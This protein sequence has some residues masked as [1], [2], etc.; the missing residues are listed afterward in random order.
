MYRSSCIKAILPS[1]HQSCAQLCCY[2]QA[3]GCRISPY[4]Q[5]QIT[6]SLVGS[7]SVMLC[8]M[9]FDA[10]LLRL[11]VLPFLLANK[12]TV[13]IMRPVPSISIRPK[14]APKKTM[15]KTIA[16]S[17]STEPRIPASA[18]CIYLRL[19]R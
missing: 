16:E 6:L 3:N 18:G 9:P 11:Q 1:E 5:R 19:P 17:G 13:P 10:V 12:N 4:H 2:C 8:Q 15:D 14:L 7:F